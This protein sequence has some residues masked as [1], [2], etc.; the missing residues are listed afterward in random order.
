LFPSERFDAK[1]SSR[2]IKTQKQ[3]HHLSLN[4]YTN[5]GHYG[6]KLIGYFLDYDKPDWI[7]QRKNFMLA[8]AYQ[9]DLLFIKNLDIA[10][11]YLYNDDVI[12]REAP[13][14]AEYVSTFLSQRLHLRLTKNFNAMSS[15]DEKL[16]VQLLSE[17]F[18]DELFDKMEVQEKSRTGRLYDGYLYE[19]RASLGGVVSFAN[20]MDKHGLLSWQTFFGIRSDFM[21]NGK[22]YK[23]TSYGIQLDMKWG[24]NEISPYVSFGENIKIPSLQ[25]SATLTHLQ[26][27]SEIQEGVEAIKLIPENSSSF[28]IGIQYSYQP[29]KLFFKEM[30]FN[31]ALYSTRIFNKMLKTRLDNVIVQRLLGEVKTKGIE[32]MLKINKVYSDINLG[33]SY[34]ILDVNNPLL[35]A[36]KPD[37]RYG[38]HVEYVPD[39]E[40]YVTGIFFYEGR[41]IAWN[42]SDQLAIETVEVPSFYDLDLI[43]GYNFYFKKIQVQLQAAGYNFLDNAGYQFYDLKKRFLQIGLAV[44]Y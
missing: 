9:G 41:S 37:R 20:K 40:W 27:L 18:H 19:N 33:L 8:G 39:A 32:G 35:Y 14:D 26:N 25:E 28:E 11:N 15:D 16:S 21:A 1:S 42:Y 24:N 6:A 7:N 3:N 30:N 2:L 22:W 36:Y 4:Y 44:K 31:F 23:T 10:L 43:F 17:Y 38:V 34:G 13:R 29:Q 12:R 5:Q